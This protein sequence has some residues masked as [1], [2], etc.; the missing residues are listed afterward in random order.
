LNAASDE[1]KNTIFKMKN[2]NNQLFSKY[3]KIKEL[4]S[5]LQEK[6]KE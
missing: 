4:N 2:D 6:L 1:A 5:E 3:K